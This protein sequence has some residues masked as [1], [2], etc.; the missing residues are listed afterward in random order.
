MIAHV[1]NISIELNELNWNAIYFVVCSF[2]WYGVPVQCA[3]HLFVA[4]IAVAAYTSWY[5]TDYALRRI[6]LAEV[7]NNNKNMC[8]HQH[9]WLNNRHNMI[10]A[11]T[12]ARTLT[13][14]HIVNWQKK[15]NSIRCWIIAGTRHVNRILKWIT[16]W[17]GF[18]AKHYESSQRVSQSLEWTQLYVNR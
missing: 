17:N 8:R 12:A 10:Y 6:I 15:Y 11:S 18:V 1:I 5:T 16:H 2:E 14:T 13:Y 3:P 9:C 7:N 4:L